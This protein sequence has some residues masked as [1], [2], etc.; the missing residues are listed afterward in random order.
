MYGTA[1]VNRDDGP[2]Y[3]DDEG[4][5]DA[6]DEREQGV[7][8]QTNNMTQEEKMHIATY[9]PLRSEQFALPQR[10]RLY[11][12]MTASPNELQQDA[13]RSL[14]SVSAHLTDNFQQNMALR[15]RHLAVGND[16]EGSAHRVMPLG[17]RITN[18]QNTFPFAIGLRIPGLMDR[19]L[20]R[21][22]KAVWVV[23][24]NVASLGQAQDVF[25][26]SNPMNQWQYEHLR[27]CSPDDLDN[28]IQYTG[29]GRAKIAVGS[30]P[31]SRLCDRIA[32]REWDVTELE[33]VNIGHVM[34]PGHDQEVEVPEHIA[35]AV[36]GEIRPYIEEAVGGLIDATKWNM[37][38]FRAD[39]EKT[40]NSPRQL[41]G[42]MAA[43]KHVNGGKKLNTDVLHT[44]QHFAVECELAFNTF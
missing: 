8:P 42:S 13:T 9:T 21:N 28:D 22:D 16:L 40:W 29:K 44:V 23:G 15:N 37:S 19:T 12:T 26:P 41:V 25:D 14:W 2:E 3:F 20:L 30:F 1:T 33:G 27:I 5:Y 35:K 4:G 6:V 24:P 36:E 31:H 7:D 10:V 34:D 32:G 11:I 17:V 18:H 38:M 39:G 43:S